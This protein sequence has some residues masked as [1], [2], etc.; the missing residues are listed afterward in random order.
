MVEVLMEVDEIQLEMKLRYDTRF[1]PLTT[2]LA[3][4][5]QCAL[6]YLSHGKRTQAAEGYFQKKHG[7]H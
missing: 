3:A 7:A 6:L 2:F 5:G 1:E 4:C